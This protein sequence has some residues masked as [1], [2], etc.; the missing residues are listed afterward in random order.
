MKYCLNVSWVN[1]TNR[2][3]IIRSALVAGFTAVAL[4]GQEAPTLRKGNTEI[5][6][7]VGGG[8]GLNVTGSVNGQ[9]SQSISAFH[10]EYGG[11]AGYAITKNFFLVGESSYFPA[12]GPSQASISSKNP[13]NGTTTTTFSYDRRLTEFNGGIHYRL[14]VPESR[15][16]PY[17][18]GGIGAA[19]FFSSDV[20]ETVTC[21]SGCNPGPPNNHF[22][23]AQGATAFEAAVGAGVR[24]YFTEHIGFRGE[25]RFYHPFGV[26]N[27]GS[28]YRVSGGLFFQLK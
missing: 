27:L 18:A 13:N 5:G 6:V 12:L 14:P 19:H 25:F 7:F 9:T 4:L 21:T 16:V 3:L 8:Y 23:T 24:M 17:L 22:A 11:D 28:F 10:I 20:T 15:F 1:M 26:D 2:K